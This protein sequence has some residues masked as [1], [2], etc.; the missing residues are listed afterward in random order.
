MSP[1]L[2][3][4]NLLLVSLLKQ[5]SFL[6]QLAAYN[7][8][9]DWLGSGDEL[10]WSSGES[11]DELVLDR[12]L[13]SRDTDPSIDLTE[14]NK[15]ANTQTRAGGIWSGDFLLVDCIELQELEAAEVHVERFQSS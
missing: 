10:W 7:Y 4:P 15:E 9:R 14:V 13:V 1:T 2:I 11:R 3:D 5:D 12:Q 6:L 8:R